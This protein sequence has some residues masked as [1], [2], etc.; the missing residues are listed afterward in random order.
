MNYD[1]G[2]CVR[3]CA[4]GQGCGGVGNFWDIMYDT[5]DTC[6]RVGLYFLSI[7][8]AERIQSS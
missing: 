4:E 8:Q 1:H 3:D 7:K 2:K 5:Q 6:C